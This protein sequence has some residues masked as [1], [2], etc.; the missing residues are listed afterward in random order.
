[1]KNQQV[2]KAYYIPQLV[3]YGTDNFF[4]ELTKLFQKRVNEIEV[5]NEWRIAYI[6]TLHLYIL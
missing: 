5:P 4:N 3:K 2:Q 6:P 1:M